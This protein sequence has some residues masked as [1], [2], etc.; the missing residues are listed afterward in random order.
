MKDAGY[1]VS[2]YR[3]V[4][5][6]FGTLSDFDSL[7]E[8]AHQLGLSIIIDQVISHSSDQH[9]WFTESRSNH[10][11]PKAD[12]Y[13]WADPLADGCVPNNWLSVFGGSAWSWDS[14]RR[15]YYYHNFLAAQPDLNFHNPE[16]IEQ[17]L[18]DLEFWLKKGVNGFRLDAV[19]HCFHDKLLR[20]NPPNPAAVDGT[21]TSCCAAHQ[22]QSQ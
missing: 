12:W 18:T 17:V 10:H 2:N 5:P 21:T 6:I 19:N 20:N 3:D 11:N 1:D 15:Q 16:V 7:V 13:V 14:R 22:R 8:R 9:P 4:D